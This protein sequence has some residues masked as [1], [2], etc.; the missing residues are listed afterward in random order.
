MLGDNAEEPM[1]GQRVEAQAQDTTAAAQIPAPHVSKATTDGPWASGVPFRRQTSA[2]T[3]AATVGLQARRVLRWQATIG[4]CC[5][6]A[7][8]P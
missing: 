1:L 2:V 5:A 3:R 6:N 8:G 4:D 7:T